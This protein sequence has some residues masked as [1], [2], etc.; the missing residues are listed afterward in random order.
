MNEITKILEPKEKIIWDG[1]PRYAP[2]IISTILVSI[3]VGLFAGIWIGGFFK[4]IIIGLISGFL[5]VIIG[6]II[7]HLAYTFTQYELTNRR[8]IIQTG[9]FGRN[10]RSINY[11]D[12]KNASVARGLF[13]WLFNTGTVNVFTGEMQSTGGKHPRIKSKYDS[14]RYLPD[15]YDVLK[16]LQEH[17]TEMEENLY[18]GKNVVRKVKVVK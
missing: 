18:G 3:L 5:I 8:A 9:I 17:L 16:K 1:T 15:A 14:F 6:S 4:N 7:G 12:I 11:D 2:Y 10:F 13:N